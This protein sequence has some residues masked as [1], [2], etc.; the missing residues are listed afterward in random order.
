MYVLRGLV[1]EGSHLLL[2]RLFALRRQVPENMKFIT[3]DKGLGIKL[4]LFVSSFLWQSD[5][6]SIP[7]VVQIIL[8][9]SDAVFFF[10]QLGRAWTEAD[11]DWG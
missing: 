7:Y 3:L 4:S 9:P 6:F 11:G 8:S 2:M 5:T 1:T 10:L